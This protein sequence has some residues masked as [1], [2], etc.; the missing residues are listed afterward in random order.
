MSLGLDLLGARICTFDCLYCE[1]GVTEAL[2]TVR[3]PYVPA[4]R[5]LDELAA[6]KAAGH[7][8]PDVVTLG[9]LGEPCL[10]TDLGDI[11]AGTKELFPDIPVAVLT[12][13]S[14]TPDPDVRGALCAAD[15]VLPSMD[16]LVASEYRRLNRPQ[17][18]IGLDAIRRGLLDFR[19]MY[20]GSIFLEVL[21]LAG[22][23]DTA[24]NLELLQ[25]FCRELAPT[26]V[27]VVTMS[28]PG[29]YAGASAVSR[30]VL[31]RFREVLG[32]ADAATT[33]S[34]NAAGHGPTALIGRH[35]EELAARIAASVARRPQT[36]EGLAAG[37]DVPVTQVRQAL[38][39]LLRTGSVRRQPGEDDFF[40]SG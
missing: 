24:E 15:L 35:S 14:L 8:M 21:L 4:R 17:A 34:G 32:S 40:Y 33:V 1:A 27:D 2:T 22:L 25:G 38:A 18:A 10:N 26:R 30:E 39:A 6:W 16:T 5:I 23:N 36:E 37:L 28:R 11:I 31:D 9:G 29:A 3:K 12:N 20:G 7:A 13:S 19:A